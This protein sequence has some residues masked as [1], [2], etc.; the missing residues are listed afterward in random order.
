MPNKALCNRAVVKLNTPV[1][2]VVSFVQFSNQKVF[3]L[4]GRDENG[5]EPTVHGYTLASFFHVNPDS[6]NIF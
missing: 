3:M 4:H 5:R 2:R 6:S 1:G